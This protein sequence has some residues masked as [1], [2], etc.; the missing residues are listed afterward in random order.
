MKLAWYVDDKPQPH[1]DINL[2][3]VPIMLM[4]SLIFEDHTYWRNYYYEIKYALY[5]FQSKLC[6]LSKL[7]AKKLIQHGEQENEWGGYFII[8]GKERLMRLLLN[9]RRNYP[10]AIKRS[11][12]KNRDRNF[13]DIGVMIR[14]VLEDQTSVVSVKLYLS[15]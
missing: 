11:S 6:N 3:S 8:K 10:I 2:A 5:R 1:L 13:S 14:C 12:W 15:L 9:P 7:S 4:V